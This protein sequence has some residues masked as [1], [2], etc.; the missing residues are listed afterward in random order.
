MNMKNNDRLNGRKTLKVTGFLEE[1]EK[2]DIKKNIDIVELFAYF[3]VKL[4]PSGKGFKGICPFHNDSKTPSLSVSRDK[5]GV[6]HCFGCGEAGDAFDLVEKMKG[7]DFKGALK[8]LKDWRGLSS[9]SPVSADL[10]LAVVSSNN[11]GNP[12]EGSSILAQSDGERI[13]D[14][15]TVKNYYHK[16]LYDHPEAI[17]Y[18]Q[19][20]GFK[21]PG[22][23]ARL[24]ERFQ[25]GFAGGS[26][27]SIIGGI[28]KQTLTEAGILS[29]KGKEHFKN[30]L[31]FPIFDDTGAPDGQ[32][33]SFYGRDIDDNSNFKHRY[34]KGSH[35]G[36]FNRKASKVYDEIVLTECIIDALSLIETGLENVQAI[37]GTN[38]FTDEHLETL[39]AD[40]VKTVVLAL[41]SDEA[42][43]KASQALKE[44]FINEGFKV[45]LLSAY[46]GKD[47]NEA[48]V[49]GALKKDDLTEL[50]NQLA[51]FEPDS[52]QRLN[53][54]FTVKEE[55]YSTIFNFKDILYKVSGVKEFFVTSLRVNI[56]A[57]YQGERYFDNLDLYAARSRS[58]FASQVSRIL[59]VEPKRVEKDLSEIVD[60]FE[61]ERDRRAREN[62]KTTVI[63]EMTEEE[64]EAGLKFLKS[65]NLFDEIVQDMEKIGYV[66]EDLNKQL[67]YI[68]ASS[69]ILDDP[70]SILIL[71][72]SAA[73]KSRLVETVEKL[74]P[75]EDVVAVT[76]LS[77]QAL[78]YVADFKHKFFTLGESVHSD[79]VEHQIREMLSR[80]ELSRLVTV[81][82]E[83][84]GKMG[85]KLVKT[86][87]IVSSVLSTT[88]HNMNPENASRYFVTNIDESRDQTQRI[89]ESQRKKYSLGRHLEKLHIVPEIVKKHH[90]AQRLLRKVLIVNPFGEFL[91]FPDHLMRT[92]RDNERFLDLIACV[93]FLRQYQKPVKRASQEEGQEARLETR[94]TEF[95]ECDLDDYRIGF[96]VM[97]KG[98]LGA[99]MND[100]PHQAAFLYEELRR[101]MR[102]KAERE[103]L[104][105]EEVSMTQREI[106]ERTG[107]NQMFV[108]RYLRVLTEYEYIK[109]RGNHFRGGT[110]SY[111]LLSDENIEKMDLSIIPTPEEM[112]KRITERDRL[113]SGSVEKKDPETL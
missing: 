46:G 53:A 16:K 36:I 48:L 107:L 40:R 113:K 71:S 52:G 100:I 32:T 90:A 59:G 30:C 7:F 37:Y 87:M 97:V 8:F 21:T 20:R 86:P 17:E 66:G 47:W 24:Y 1:F 108:K 27:L 72:E 18:L 60:Y 38:G 31:I 29:D 41:D 50:I 84:T 89:H 76:S 67:L 104:K 78:N 13:K 3:N 22:I 92:R 28:Q 82:D 80:K 11:G 64:R 105:P 77:D 99:T 98:I 51:V 63:P 94:L 111:S 19:K 101:V 56:R 2:D 79:I 75:P 95:I 110:A 33:I 102:E 103:N 39:K 6:Y 44:R 55:G 68:C 109:V 73:G 15:N 26:L 69:R 9:Y 96:N 43:Q 106:R 49:N 57:E 34:L 112:E 35:K 45:K 62:E 65:P 81:K 58:S 61:A 74:L 83:K 10:P 93:C 88:S 85:S 25:I 4:T 70:I 12:P 14:L 54:N 42:G 23:E 91:N 5:G